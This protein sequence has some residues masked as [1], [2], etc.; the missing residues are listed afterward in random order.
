MMKALVIYDSVFGN[1]EKVAQ[2][3]GAALGSQGQVATLPVSSK[4]ASWNAPPSGPGA[5]CPRHEARQR[6]KQR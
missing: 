4:P 6:Q 5:C 1:T 2:A 3:I